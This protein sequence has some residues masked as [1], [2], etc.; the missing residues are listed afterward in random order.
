MSLK[1]NAQQRIMIDS[2]SGLKIYPPRVQSASTSFDSS[3]LEFEYPIYQGDALFSFNIFGHENIS[4]RDAR[5]E[6]E[7]VLSI[8]HDWILKDA[9]GMKARW[10]LAGDDFL[11]LCELARG[12]V[13]VLALRL[14][15]DEDARYSL[16]ADAD[17]L[18][19][20]H[21]IVPENAIRNDSGK[22]VLAD[23]LVPAHIDEEGVP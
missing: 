22:Y 10:N 6:R 14:N 3:R 9:L 16:I 21:V 17:V 18:I 12:L 13:G 1:F 23:V 19:Q 5:R 2:N 15:S 20:N 7:L 4:Q 8:N 11:F